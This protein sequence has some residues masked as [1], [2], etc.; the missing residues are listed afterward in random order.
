MEEIIRFK[1]HFGID[2][3]VCCYSERGVQQLS[4]IITYRVERAQYE[5][6]REECEEMTWEEYLWFLCESEQMREKARCA[7]LQAQRDFPA[8]RFD[9]EHAKAGEDGEK[10][11]IVRLFEGNRAEGIVLLFLF[12]AELE[13]HRRLRAKRGETYTLKQYMRDLH[14][15]EGLASALRR[16]FE[17][18]VRTLDFRAAWQK[19]GYE[20][21]EDSLEG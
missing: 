2:H 1:E 18:A 5:L 17:G 3:I 15:E 20:P 21:P 10:I 13:H 12:K 19:A 14:A 9:F 6:W 8:E 7:A 16:G 4:N 11:R